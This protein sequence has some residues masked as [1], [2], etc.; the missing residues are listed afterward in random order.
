[1]KE[2]KP[3]RFNDSNINEIQRFFGSINYDNEIYP[4]KITVKVIKYGENKA[5]SYE[6]MQIES[7]ITQKELSGQS[8]FRRDTWKPHTF[9]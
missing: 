7:P 1:L 2:T 9:N 3:D 6:V 8:I 5:Y 4:V